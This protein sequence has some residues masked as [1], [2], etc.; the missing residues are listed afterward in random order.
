MKSIAFNRH[1]ISI[2][3]FFPCLFFRYFFLSF[4]PTAYFSMRE[5]FFFFASK[6]WSSSNC[7][8][9]YFQ[10]CCWQN[11]WLQELSPTLAS[12]WPSFPETNELSVNWNSIYIY[13]LLDF[14]F[15]SF[16]C[17]CGRKYVCE[18]EGERN[19]NPMLK[20]RITDSEESWCSDAED[21]KQGRS[22]CAA[23]RGLTSVVSSSVDSQMLIDQHRR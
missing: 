21:T 19:S 8:V 3:S 13:F 22:A 15:F 14:F 1:A 10:F 7:I 18:R 11:F 16:L 4:F 17:V 6:N 5:F 20:N 23:S 9:S 12:P 2:L